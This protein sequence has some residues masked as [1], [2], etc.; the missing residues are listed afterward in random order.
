MKR[1]LTGVFL[2]LCVAIAACGDEGNPT[3]EIA[4][5]PTPTASV[6][7]PS[8]PTADVA[9]TDVAE[10]LEPDATVA[11]ASATASS[12]IAQA[13]SYTEAAASVDVGGFTLDEIYEL[14]AGGCGMTLWR[15]EAQSA[16]PGDRLF[17]L[18]NGIEDN[19]MLMKLNGEAVRFR[20]TAQSG[21]EFYG[22]Y[23]E[24]TFQ[25]AP[26]DITVEVSVD[27]GGVMGEIESVSIPGGTIKVIMAGEEVTIPVVG[28]AGC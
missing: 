6:V 28:D 13:P 14:D 3:A 7:E 27:K 18:V 16:A 10:P 22:Q 11:E 12:P 8:E 15:V 21:E 26:G 24:Q 1:V 9:E 19:S 20:R 5:T 2:G 17:I 4:E 25:D 23:E